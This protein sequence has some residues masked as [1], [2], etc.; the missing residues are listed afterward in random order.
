MLADLPSEMDG[1][2]PSNAANQLF[3]VDDNQTKVDAKKAQF[4]H[5][6]VAKRLFLC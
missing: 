1:E 3:T 5:T 6:Y 4:F 2:A